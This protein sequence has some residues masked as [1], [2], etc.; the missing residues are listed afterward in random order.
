M[1]QYKPSNSDARH[2]TN[3]NCVNLMSDKVEKKSDENSLLYQ[4]LNFA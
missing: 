2:K 3:A 4:T 1:F